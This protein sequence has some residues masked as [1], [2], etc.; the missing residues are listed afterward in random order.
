MAEH[1][2]PAAVAE[3]AVGEVDVGVA[4]AG[5]GDPD[6]HLAAP[7]WIERDGLDRDRLTRAPQHDGRISIGAARNG[8]LP[9]IRTS[10]PGKLSR[11][12]CGSGSRG[13]ALDSASGGSVVSQISPILRGQRVW[14]AQPLGGSAALGI[15]PLEPDP[16]P[17]DV[18]ERRHGRQQRLG[19]GVVGAAEHRSAGPISITR[20]R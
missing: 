6:E 15:S 9:D 12:G 4:D 8:L 5:G 14:N 7:W 16:L 20:P 13:R 1:H 18:V 2:R 3:R 11:A 17:A 10:Q 19:V